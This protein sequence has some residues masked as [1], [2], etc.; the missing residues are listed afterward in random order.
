MTAAYLYRYRIRRADEEG[1]CPNCGLAV[2][3]LDIAWEIVDA[4]DR[5]DIGEAFESGH[6]SRACAIRRAFRL[7]FRLPDERPDR[8]TLTRGFMREARP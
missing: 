8:S 4:P 2:R 6:C 7:G 5:H 3:V 1:P